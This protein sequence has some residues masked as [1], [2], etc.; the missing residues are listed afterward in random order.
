M[1][2]IGKNGVPVSKQK[3]SVWALLVCLLT[4]GCAGVP[5]YAEQAS[6]TAAPVLARQPG[7]NAAGNLDGR[8]PAHQA[9]STQSCGI[10]RVANNK[11]AV[12][13]ES[14]RSLDFRLGATVKAMLAP[15]HMDIYPLT[16]ANPRTI[17]IRTGD[18]IDS[19]SV[20]GGSTYRL[21]SRSSRWA[22][23]RC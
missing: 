18:H 22:I 16:N 1:R 5:F 8:P 7:R 9:T 2:E 23:S 17:G 10:I 6:P 15:G 12:I 4:V 19:K 11:F 13:N 21:H 20:V 14:D 3:I